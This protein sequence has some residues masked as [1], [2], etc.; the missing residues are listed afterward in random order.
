VTSRDDSDGPFG[1]TA[2]QEAEMWAAA[3]EIARDQAAACDE[4]LEL[5]RSFQ[6]Q[7]KDWKNGFAY[8]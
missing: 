2:T 4:A 1:L 6:G 3:E 5:L 8:M 7:L